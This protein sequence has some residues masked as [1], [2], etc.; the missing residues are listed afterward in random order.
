LSELED[1]DLVPKSSEPIPQSWRSW[2]AICLETATRTGVDNVDWGS[3]SSR[4]KASGL[5]SSGSATSTRRNVHLEIRLSEPLLLAD[6]FEERCPRRGAAC[7]RRPSVDAGM[8]LELTIRR[9]W[10]A[11]ETR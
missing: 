1:S 9:N 3:S 5:S 7:G 8:A 2:K 6:S 10:R 4:T 11:V